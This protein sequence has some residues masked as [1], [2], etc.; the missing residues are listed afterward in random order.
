LDATAYSKARS[1]NQ[2]HRRGR[3][4]SGSCAVSVRFVG[5]KTDELGD[6]CVELLGAERLGQEVVRA[7]LNR[8]RVLLFLAGGGE[9]DARDVAPA[10]IVAHRGQDIQSAQVRHHQIQQNETDVGLALERV[11]RFASVIDESDMKW[12]LLEL[13]L[14]DAADVRFVIGDE[15]MARRIRVAGRTFHESSDESGDVFPVAPQLEEQLADVRA[16]IEEH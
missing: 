2:F 10:V 13:H 8:A 9:N 7:E 11:H 16:R 1:V 6:S 5:W 12:A 4:P 15:H 3:P 14:D